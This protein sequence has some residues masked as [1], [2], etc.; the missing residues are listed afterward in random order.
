MSDIVIIGGGIAG[1]SAAAELAPHAA[2][3]VIE[4]EDA[5]AYHASGRS[6]AMFLQDY[7]NAT[8]RELNRAGASF[9]HKAGV[10]TPR[11]MMMIARADQ[12][13]AFVMEFPSLGLREIP[14]KEARTR[15]PILAP[16]VTLAAA[17]D[18]VFDLDTDRLIQVFRRIAQDHGADI[19]T[20]ARATAITH[21]G[22]GWNVETT[23]GDYSA[24]TLVNAAGAWADQIA[25]MAGLRPMGLQPFR[26]SMARIPAPGGHDVTRWPFMD[27]VGEAWYAKP[28]AGKLIVSPSEED[29]MSPF[30]A[31]PDDMVI[32]Q[33]L[34]RW[35]EMVTTPVTRV[36]TTWAGLRTFA[37]DRALVIGRDA[38]Q[39]A[40]FWLAGQ[41]GYGF[42]TAPAAAW[43]TR[44]LIA[45]H[46]PALDDA[47]V[48]ALCP[49]RFGD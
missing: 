27:G 14:I 3:T 22:G 13:S 8:V 42:Q 18:D 32:A 40:F 36:E 30:D 45:G 17:R 34:A 39:P 28:D 24:T 19:I 7:G 10:L 5:L 25:T 31:W 23:K 9:L 38:L 48:A 41:G 4:A 33:G 47:T 20:G 16:H 49:H 15:V 2:V 1:I 6:A 35:E 37:P 44:D 12:H 46:A 29:P 43:L 21:S 26:R 11:G